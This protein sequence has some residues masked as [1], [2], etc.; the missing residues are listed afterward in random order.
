MPHI[1][2]VCS[3]RSRLTAELETAWKSE[4]REE[5]HSY[6][7]CFCVDSWNKT[8]EKQ[9]LLDWLRDEAGLVVETQGTAVP[10]YWEVAQ[11]MV[12][13]WVQQLSRDRQSASQYKWRTLEQFQADLMAAIT[14]VVHKSPG[15]REKLAVAVR[16]GGFE[17]TTRRVERT[18]G[19]LTRS[20][21]VYWD[22]QLFG[23]RIIVDQQWALDGLYTVLER[24]N[25]QRGSRPEVY[26]ELLK[27]RGRFTQS[28]LHNWVW[29]GD[30]Q[31]D[32]QKLLISFMERCGLCFRIR[33]AASAWREEDLYV[34]FEHLPMAK[35]LQL[36]EEFD[37]CLP[38]LNLHERT[39]K[40]SFLHKYDWQMFLADAGNSYGPDAVYAEDALFFHTKNDQVV[41]ITCVINQ[42]TGFGGTIT[43]QVVGHNADELLNELG[44]ELKN[45][46]PDGHVPGRRRSIPPEA[47]KEVLPRE[48]VFISYA[49]NTAAEPEINYEEPVE[50]IEQFL[51]RHNFEFEVSDPQDNEHPP[52]ANASG[53]L[54]R[55]RKSVKRHG[56]LI[57]FMQRGARSTKVIVVHSKRYWESVNCMFELHTLL[58]ELENNV[59][60][61]MAETVITVE[62][63][64]SDIQNITTLN[65]YL[66]FWREFQQNPGYLPTRM[67]K[68][69]WDHAATADHARSTIRT[70][71]EFISDINEL[72][73]RWADGADSVLEHIRQRLSLPGRSATAAKDHHD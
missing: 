3:R 68:V 54:I 33:D 63:A 59:N 52:V 17:L 46:F 35:E 39:I 45:R 64:S 26:R 41:L 28:D 55:D 21:W 8:G 7:K 24:P 12:E 47:A 48:S 36:Q 27:S 9:R 31:S 67:A 4:V 37:A 14:Q 62:H 15:D 65:K 25:L 57:E 56:S 32:E 1:A 19:F 42:T 34:S 72:N 18:L 11:Q 49:W 61:A 50:A 71:G 6:C 53:V 20:G 30:F 22:P 29:R 16:D 23:G 66:D 51:R 44:D 69:G 60:R 13:S 73:L 70:F 2:I 58:R 38:D 40:S 43:V 10:R 5:F